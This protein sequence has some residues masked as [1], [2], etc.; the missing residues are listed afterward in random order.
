MATI[1]L[2]QCVPT[3]IYDDG[4]MH[5]VTVTITVGG[6]AGDGAVNVAGGAPSSVPTGGAGVVNV[7]GTIQVVLHYVAPPNKP[8]TVD[9]TY[10]LLVR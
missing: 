9:V 3:V 2:K 6:A 8:Q 5:N 7:P 4:S 10:S 1:T